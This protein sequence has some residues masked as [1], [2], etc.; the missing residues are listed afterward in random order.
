MAFTRFRP[1][2]WSARLLVA[3]RKALVYGGPV[4][5]NRDWEGEVAEAGD[6]VRVT[7]IG[8]PTIAEYV[9]NST[10]I[11]P[12]ELTDAQRTIVIDESHY[13]A[14][15][16]D[17]ID[18]RQ[19]AGNVIPEAMNRAAYQLA[20]LVDQTIAAL[21]TS[22][23][24]ANVVSEVAID[25]SSP[26]SWAT[27]AAKAYD[28]VLV[29]LKVKLDEANVPTTG[30]YCVV[31]PS[32]H[33]VLLR[34]PRFTDASASGSTTP[35]ANG[36]VGR[37]AGFDIAI[38]NNSP[39]PETGHRV[40]QAGTNAGITLAEQINKTEAYRP[41]SGFADAVKGLILFG[42]KM[43]RPEMIATCVVDLS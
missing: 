19:A 20:D 39:T 11:S 22:A 8:D 5:V 2:I 29:P 25:T 28:E 7:S 42:T 36:M 13:F 34:D 21:Y 37:A 4:V 33:G 32:F 12:Q 24:S 18:S 38:S 26:T 35:L 17:D 16:V 23:Q 27:E 40:I 41:E 43:I 31:P 1:E 6:T 10:V 15:K 3:L 14:F 9:P 30:R